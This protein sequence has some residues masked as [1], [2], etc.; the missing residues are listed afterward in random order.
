MN[1]LTF[2]F[3]RI[4]VFRQMELFSENVYDNRVKRLDY[5]IKLSASI[6]CWY[7]NALKN[8]RECVKLFGVNHQT[9]FESYSRLL[10]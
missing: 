7:P 1:Q 10:C 5:A 9:V 6:N 2:A 3:S 8:V 4:P